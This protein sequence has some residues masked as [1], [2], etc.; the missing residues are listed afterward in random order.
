[1]TNVATSDQPILDLR[2]AQESFIPA[3]K[4]QQRLRSAHKATC[5]VRLIL[6]FQIVKIEPWLLSSLKDQYATFWP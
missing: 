2:R 6:A 4:Y 5:V 3:A 1:M